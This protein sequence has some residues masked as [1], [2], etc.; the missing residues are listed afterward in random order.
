MDRTRAYFLAIQRPFVFA[1]A[2]LESSSARCRDNAKFSCMTLTALL[3]SLTLTARLADFEK[4]LGRPRASC[5]SKNLIAFT[6]QEFGRRILL[7]RPF[8]C[9][10]GGFNIRAA[11]DYTND[12]AAALAQLDAKRSI[13]H[14]GF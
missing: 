11:S 1:A 8:E 10:A 4:S 2:S 12:I 3:F 7:A 5:F 6:Q 9:G 14:G 13:V